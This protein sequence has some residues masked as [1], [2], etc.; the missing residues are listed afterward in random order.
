MWIV[1]TWEELLATPG[2]RERGGFL[3]SISANEFYVFN[4]SMMVFSG[5][6]ID[7]SMY[8]ENSCAY[9]VFS[10]GKLFFIEKWMCKEV[11]P[12]EMFKDKFN[13]NLRGIK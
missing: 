3:R 4:E 12:R 6:E 9:E 13:K 11:C 1:K 7:E 8:T 5:M 2:T 10:N